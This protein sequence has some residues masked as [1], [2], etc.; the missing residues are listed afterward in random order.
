MLIVSQPSKTLL[1]AV[2]DSDYLTTQKGQALDTNVQGATSYVSGDLSQ[3]TPAV[4]LAEGP[5]TTDENIQ[6]LVY[7]TFEGKKLDGLEVINSRVSTSSTAPN[8]F[9][10]F[11]RL[12]LNFPGGDLGITTCCKCGTPSVS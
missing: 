7:G 1:V 9:G 10:I 5:P 2:M 12:H 11:A 8:S 3:I 6:L 4:L